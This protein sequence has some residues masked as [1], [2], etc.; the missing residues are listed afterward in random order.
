MAKNEKYPVA[1]VS[2]IAKVF[3]S[4][5]P[6]L[7]GY[8]SGPQLVG[9]FNGLGYTDSY[10]F[11]GVGIVTPTACGLSRLQYA[12]QRLNELNES[13][14]L[15]DALVKFSESINALTEPIQKIENVFQQYNI[16]NPMPKIEM[17]TPIIPVSNVPTFD[18]PALL[19]GHNQSLPVYKSKGIEQNTGNKNFDKEFDEIPEG[20]KVVFI[21][22]SWDDEEHKT[23][24]CN[25][26]DD[27]QRRGVWVLVDQYLHEGYP[28][29]HF[30]NKGLEVA[31]KVL[32][33]GT[34]N[35]RS[36]SILSSNG[37]VKYE[38]AIIY[39][40]L[41]VN[42]V[43]TKFIPITRK[44]EFDDALP[45][46]ISK[47]VGFDFRDDANYESNLNELVRAIND[48]P[49][50]KRPLLGSSSPVEYTDL[51]LR[52]QS[53][54]KSPDSDFRKIQDRKWLERLLVNFSFDLMDEYLNNY[55]T[56]VDEKVFI[57]IDIWDSI[58]AKS[59]FKIYDP[60]LNRIIREFHKQWHNIK[61]LGFS[62]YSIEPGQKKAK[63]LGLVH[64]E[65]MSKEAKDVYG[66]IVTLQQSMLPLLQEMAEYI[67]D[68]FQIDVVDTSAR[69]LKSLE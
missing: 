37:G 58:I 36:R 51:S 16:S 41:M 33:I 55:P 14:R 17:Q 49:K 27:L 68:N 53:E 44:G 26:S 7:P 30:M 48:V 66:Q 4:K 23:W 60:Q 40:E 42:G 3:A 57:S 69:F 9:M 1:V 62:Y 67:Q 10:K 35:Y 21:S 63:Y 15:P 56:Y 22:Y 59:T 39:A 38:G 47:R 2:E 11:P 31:D 12:T 50:H 6:N 18:R 24:V 29:I 65:F 8:L 32:I 34:P 45:P 46:H 20:V 61:L 19:D 28:L 43:S 25:L 54:L 64:D 52:E 13:Y 5:D